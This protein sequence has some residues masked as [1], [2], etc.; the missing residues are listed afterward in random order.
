MF[1][2]HRNYGVLFQHLFVFT[3]VAIVRIGCEIHRDKQTAS[4]K[5]ARYMFDRDLSLI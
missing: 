4:G 1:N 5:A 2:L 3:I